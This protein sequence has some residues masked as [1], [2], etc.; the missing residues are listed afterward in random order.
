MDI[1][2]SIRPWML[3]AALAVATPVSMSAAGPA[4]DSCAG[5]EA[6]LLDGLL[7]PYEGEAIRER[8]A[9]ILLESVHADCPLAAQVAAGLHALGDAH[10][11]RLLSRD[12]VAAER[13][14]IRLL[15]RGNLMML[16]RLS[17]LAHA[18]GDW[19]QA[20]GWAQLAGRVATM[21]DRRTGRQSG[22]EATRLLELFAER[23]GSDE[24]EA[25]AAIE[26]VMARHGD[27]VRA[28]LVAFDAARSPSSGEQDA[29]AAEVVADR[30]NHGVLART[31]PPGYTRAQIQFVLAIGPDGRVARRWWFDAVP[32]TSL[33]DAFGPVVDRFRFNTS[34]LT[35]T[36]WAVQPIAFANGEY[37]L[38]DAPASLTRRPR[39]QDGG[40]F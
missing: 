6:A 12:D 28:G 37:G 25:R 26:A 33:A 17:D 31:P 8:R 29:A 11:A 38:G 13:G 16:G 36:R 14:F 20:M 19:E 27:A 4:P 24:G 21:V 32:D 3:V 35:E 5:F 18:R 10:P 2:R 34:S 30:R 40:P 9:S 1:T 22:H 7:D 15:E 39:D 23:P